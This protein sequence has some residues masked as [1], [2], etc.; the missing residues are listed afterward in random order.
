MPTDLVI[1]GRVNCQQC[2]TTRRK[3]E[4]LGLAHRY[5]DLDQDP[6][7]AHRLQVEGHRTL[8]VVEAGDLV[9]A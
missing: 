4:A 9:W 6:E 5:V 7:A 2:H 3:A 8:P 1:Y